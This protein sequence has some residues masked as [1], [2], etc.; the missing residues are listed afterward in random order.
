[1]KKHFFI[2]F[3]LAIA[4]G[5]LKAQESFSDKIKK[6]FSLVGHWEIIK[7]DV[8]RASTLTNPGTVPE[9][10]MGT[11]SVL[12]SSELGSYGSFDVAPGGNI[13]GSGEAQYNYHVSAGSTAMS[14]PMT[15]MVLPVGASAVMEGDDGVRKFSITG[16]AD[17]V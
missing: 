6:A 3:L 11:V 7:M 12:I 14:V 13:N 2:F 8:I 10:T 17:L 16:S 4:C 9:A 1:M 5:T 15:N